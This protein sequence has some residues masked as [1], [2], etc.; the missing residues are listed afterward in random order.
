MIAYVRNQ[1]T[2]PAALTTH[3]QKSAFQQSLHWDG[4]VDLC[5]LTQ[6]SPR[7]YIT[8][9]RREWPYPDSSGIP[10]PIQVRH[11]WLFAASVAR[12]P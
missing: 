10:G 7:V 5:G 8:V 9:H 12:S 1:L 2:L 4:E 11:L 3:Q 6:L